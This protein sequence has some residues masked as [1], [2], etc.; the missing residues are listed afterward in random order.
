M[1]SVGFEGVLDE[2]HSYEQMFMILHIIIIIGIHV[3][4]TPNIHVGGCVH[5]S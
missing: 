5:S 1:A 2:L 4:I 3:V